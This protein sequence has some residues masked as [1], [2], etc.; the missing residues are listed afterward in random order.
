M[1]LPI[2]F[3]K[4][5]EDMLEYTGIDLKGNRTYTYK[6]KDGCKIKVTAG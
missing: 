4:A 6:L 3:F 2:Q 1:F 5:C